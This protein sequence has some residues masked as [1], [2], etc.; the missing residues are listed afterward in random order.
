MSGRTFKIG[1]SNHLNFDDVRFFNLNGPGSY[2]ANDQ[3]SK[4]PSYSMG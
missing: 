3:K 2:N 4:G 1:R